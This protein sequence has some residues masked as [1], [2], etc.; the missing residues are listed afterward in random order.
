M[1]N[2][3][4]VTMM[5]GVG[6]PIL[7]PTACLCLIAN[8]MLD[9]FLIFYYY[10][11]PPDYDTKLH[12]E[13]VAKM[14]KAVLLFFAMGAWMISNNQLLPYEGMPLEPSER[15]STEFQSHHL[16]TQYVYGTLDEKFFYLGPAIPLYLFFVFSLLVIIFGNILE[17][18]KQRF[19]VFRD[20]FTFF[21]F[22]DLEEG[23]DCY[24]DSINRKEI[25]WTHIE[26]ELCRDKFN[27]ATMPKEIL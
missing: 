9:V 27:Y 4:F 26:E 3:V 19:W 2:I 21:E 12:V 7:F 20:N 25:G 16:W 23:F 17:F 13:Q 14:E 15:A 10:R 22:E 1:M 24:F 6:L 11:K 18:L 5:Y 8:Y